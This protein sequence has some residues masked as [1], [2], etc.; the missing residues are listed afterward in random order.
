MAAY[1]SLWHRIVPWVGAH[2]LHLSYP[3][4]IFPEVNGGSDTT[5]DY[6][7]SLCF[8]A[9][10]VVATVVWSVLDRQRP[11][12]S[13]LYRWLRA[14]VRFVLAC[15]MFSY[16]GGKVI[17]VQMM[18]PSLSALMEPLGNL[19]P[20]QLS[21]NYIGAAP[22][23]EIFAGTVELLGGVLL[24]IPGLTTL[25]AVVSLGAMT[26]VF[27]LNVGYGIPVKFWA[28]HLLLIAAFLLL[29]DVR[30]LMNLFVLNREVEPGR[31]PPLFERR[32]LNRAAWA[33]QWLLGLFVLGTT[34]SSVGKLRRDFLRMRSTNPLYGIWRVD[35]FTADGEVR[36]PLLT[37]TLRWQ[38]VIVS[39]PQTV[40]IQEMDG[41]LSPYAAAVDT[42]K[43]TLS[44]KPIRAALAS[45]PWWNEWQSTPVTWDTTDSRWRGAT[46]LSYRLPEPEAM[47]VEGLM[48]GHRLRVALRKEDRRFILMTRGFH[49]I[50][51]DQFY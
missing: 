3:I 15:A 7:K 10:A 17:P 47:V 12:Y 35:E 5:Y 36:S 31:R 24:L 49:W 41:Q 4:T 38:R 23:Y 32:R 19:T 50:N 48:N 2:L 42:T 22:G 34:L 20:Y 8:L 44:L 46:R 28:L 14:Y 51:E 13:K 40:T 45:S 1:E 43:S 16:G 21:W 26:N 9:I 6:V 18:P 30:R 27:M 11:G 39:S 37:D 25:G 29:P 33:V